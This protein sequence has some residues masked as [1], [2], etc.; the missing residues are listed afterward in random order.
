MK[1]LK[2]ISALS[3]GVLILLASLFLFLGIFDATKVKIS[4]LIGTIIWFLV[5]PF[6][7]KEK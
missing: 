4:M 6:W 7:M 2:L 5:T 3:I 1:I